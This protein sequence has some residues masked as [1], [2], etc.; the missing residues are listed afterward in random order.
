[1]ASNSHARIKLLAATDAAL[2]RDIRLDALQQNPEAF[3]STF[4]RESE[5][6]L[7]WFE[8]RLRQADIFGAFIDDDLLGIAGY[9]RHENLKQSHKAV[10]WTMYVRVTARNSGLGKLL[11]EAVVSHACGRV[12]QL[13]LSVVSDN[14]AAH[15]LYANLGFVE[16]GRE[17]KALKQ[18]RRYYDEILMVKFL[19]PN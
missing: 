15:R 18:D 3:G 19:A 14:Q 11:V 10:L 7:Q 9:M 8:E 6:P 17:P 12:E 1:M 2:F 4:E 13:Q 16:Y 5:Q